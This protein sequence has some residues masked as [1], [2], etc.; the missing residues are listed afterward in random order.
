MAVLYSNN[1]VPSLG[2]SYTPKLVYASYETSGV[3]GASTGGS[4]QTLPMN[5]LDSDEYSLASVAANQITL[6]SGV[7]DVEANYTLYQC[8]DSVIR[9]YNVTSASEMLVSTSTY[10]TNSGDYATDAC[11]LKGRIS[12]AVSSTLRFEYYCNVSR[13]VNG[14]GIGASTGGSWKHGIYKFTK[15]D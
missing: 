3:G 2:S 9:L 11:N 7:Y 15:L 8:L 1:T 4:W 13:I 12:L 14:L 6:E 10:S 5:T